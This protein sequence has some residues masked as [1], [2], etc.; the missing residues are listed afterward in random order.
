MPRC[1]SEWRIGWDRSFGVGAFKSGW[2]RGALRTG[3]SPSRNGTLNEMGDGFMARIVCWRCLGVVRCDV[4]QTFHMER[5]SEGSYK[6][7]HAMCKEIGIA[8]VNR[9]KE[10]RT[11]D[12]YKYRT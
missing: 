8:T 4:K 2:G 9:S 11:M 6:P 5:V 10:R 12:I 7:V 3:L 1:K